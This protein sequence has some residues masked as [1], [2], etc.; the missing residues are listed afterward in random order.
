MESSLNNTESM[1]MVGFGKVPTI[2]LKINF[3]RGRH[4]IVVLYVLNSMQVGNAWET[5]IEINLWDYTSM[6]IIWICTCIIIVYVCAR[7]TFKQKLV[8]L[9]PSLTLTICKSKEESFLVPAHASGDHVWQMKTCFSTFSSLRQHC[10][11]FNT[12]M[13]LFGYVPHLM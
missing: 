1:I 11:R 10:K 6:F 8:S 7:I 12:R 9:Q 2:M 13:F 5:V 4:L 3:L